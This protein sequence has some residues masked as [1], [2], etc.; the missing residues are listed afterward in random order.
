MPK[1]SDWGKKVVKKGGGSGGKYINNKSWK[2][3]TKLVFWLH[4]DSLLEDRELLMLPVPLTN[5]DDEKSVYWVRRFFIGEDD[6]SARFLD[7]LADQED[8]DADEVVMKIRHGKDRKEFRKGDLLGLKGFGFKEKIC[9]PRTESVMSVVAH[10]DPSNKLLAVPISAGK[11]IWSVINNQIDDLGADEG[12]PQINPYAIK[13]T[14]DKS[15]KRG[16]DMYD[17]HPS[18]VKMTEEIQE[19]FDEKAYDVEAECSPNDQ[20]LSD[21]GTTSEILKALCIVDCPLWDMEETD[22]EPEE[23]EEEMPENFGAQKKSKAKRKPKPKPA[24]APEPEPE[25]EEEDED[26]D[27]EEDQD[28]GE[29]HPIDAKDAEEGELYSLEDDTEITFE[30]ISRKRAVFVDEDGKKHRLAL[31]A[32]VW[33]VETEDDDEEEEGEDDEDP[34]EKTKEILVSDCEPGVMYLDSDGDDAEF[35]ELNEDGKGIF[36]DAEGDHILYE[37]DDYMTPKKKA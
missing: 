32:F 23:A 7:W 1:L 22:A 26:G 24:P 4:P 31:D 36:E 33:P 21:F 8:M 37:G 10:E 19:C 6:I 16:S 13:V 14:Y 34:T 12:N 18:G 29:I 11:A 28:D 5:D 35:I 27:D 20:D 9:T 17:A 25:P 3:D 30:G 15:E 2:E